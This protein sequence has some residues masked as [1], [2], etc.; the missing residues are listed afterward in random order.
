[1]LSTLSTKQPTPILSTGYWA[2]L[3]TCLELL[4]ISGAAALAYH[5]KEEEILQE[6]DVVKRAQQNPEYFAPLYQKYYDPVFMFINKRVDHLEITADLT[7]RVF[8]KSLKNIRRYKYQGVPFS[9]WL[10]RIAINEINMFFREQHRLART[11]NI[12]DD[13]IDIL[14]TEIEYKEPQLDP[15]V[16][17][18][19]LLEQLNENE[20][21]LVELRFFEN[22]SFREIGYLMGLSEVNAKIKTYRVIKKL[23]QTSEEIKYHD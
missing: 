3:Y 4:L 11:V 14:I 9:A 2:K 12:T 13:H 23:K 8:L 20:L 10:Y 16:L 21:Q 5:K 17:V 22:R 7:S 15:H 1:M 18:S 6:Y 19:V